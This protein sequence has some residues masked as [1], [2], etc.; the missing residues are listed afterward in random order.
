MDETIGMIELNHQR[1]LFTAP[2]PDMGES[3]SEFAGAFY[4][5]HQSV[6]RGLY[7][8][9]WSAYQL[10]SPDFQWIWTNPMIRSPDVFQEGVETLPLPL[11]CSLEERR[12]NLGSLVMPA[13]A[14]M[15]VCSVMMCWAAGHYTPPDASSGVTRRHSLQTRIILRLDQ[16]LSA[17]PEAVGG[18]LMRQ[19]ALDDSEMVLGFVYSNFSSN[20]TTVAS[21]VDVAWDGSE[22]LTEEECRVAL[23]EADTRPGELGSRA[24]ELLLQLLVPA[25]ALV[26]QCGSDEV[27]EATREVMRVLGAVGVGVCLFRSLAALSEGTMTTP[28]ESLCFNRREWT[29]A[30]LGTPSWAA[31]FV[32]SARRVGVFDERVHWV[33]LG[34]GRASPVTHTLPL[35]RLTQR[36][37]WLRWSAR[38]RGEYLSLSCTRG[39]YL[40]RLMY[41]EGWVVLVSE[42]TAA[43]VRA[44]EAGRWVGVRQPHFEVF[45]PLR[46]SYV[47]NFFQA[48]LRVVSR[49]PT[50]SQRVSNAVGRCYNAGS[51]PRQVTRCTGYV[52]QVLMQLTRDLNLTLVNSAAAQCGAA[53]SEGT[54]ITAIA[55][56]EADI[57]LGTCSIIEDRYKVVD[58]TEFFVVMR[59]T[60]ASAEPREAQS[61][62]LIFNVFSGSTWLLIGAHLL[63][64]SLGVWV[65][66]RVL[67]SLDPQFY[68]TPTHALWLVFMS[69]VNQADLR[70][71]RSVS[72]RL[73]VAVS[74]GV[75]IT[76]GAVYSGNLTA[77]FS[78][79]KYEKP[80]DSLLDLLNQPD[81]IPVI[82]ESDPNH[83]LF[84]V[85]YSQ[86]CLPP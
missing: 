61:S 4:Y 30:L 75:T 53:H 65:V 28:E 51:G 24:G 11:T 67:P 76:L 26:T 58:F 2:V 25:V 43:G 63:V 48:A 21:D 38:T 41:S 10:V 81:L 64:V 13:K 47:T 36:L 20:E 5:L 29:V 18:A 17:A 82:F 52:G 8:K 12:A 69:F 85:R 78:L 40:R 44:R 15:W 45:R 35:I 14:L 3:V 22:D 27:W 55:N 80:L 79:V 9:C 66:A 31:C 19:D 16:R 33:V 62:F 59:S 50:D 46:P 56:D 74:W 34:A 68:S 84:I 7:V 86:A 54:Q 83:K 32:R 73:V 1:S 77:W 39:E 72:G 49:Y 23:G 70:Q 42:A 60:F 37:T 71:P 6:W 57:D